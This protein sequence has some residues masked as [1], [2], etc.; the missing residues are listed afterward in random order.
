MIG[1]TISHYRIIE[2]LGEG[3]MGEV[4]LAEDKTLKRHVAIKFLSSRISVEDSDK[5]R[6]LQ[7][8]RAAA[9]INHPNVCVIH[10]IKFHDESPYIVMEYIKGVTL[11][12]F[13]RM[14]KVGSYLIDEKINYAIQI[15]DAL[16]TAHENDI[17]HRDIKS[18]NVMVTDTGQIK[19]MDFGLAK[20]RGSVRLTKSTSTVGTLAYMA[21]EQIEGRGV[22]VWRSF[23]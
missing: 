20:L 13:I 22:D 10:E 17:I 3:G 19:V 18:D 6:F 1:K 4:Y 23:I 8:A 7:E 5:K 12:E 16:H 11:R 9:A 2:K 14:N 21:P 15:A